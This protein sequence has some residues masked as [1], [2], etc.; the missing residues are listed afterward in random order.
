MSAYIVEDET[1]NKIVRGIEYAMGFHASLDFHLSLDF[2]TKCG[3]VDPQTLGEMLFD[4]NI[5]GVES[6][7]GEGEAGKF[8]P[9]D[10][11][12]QSVPPPTDT[13]FLKSLRCLLYQCSEGD[14]PE[15]PLFKAMKELSHSLALHIV[16]TSACYE[17]ATWG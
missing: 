12:Y 7:Y 17:T 9:L 4:L 10:Y 14:V 3:A 11:K 6:R 5:Q 8:R 2:Y 15:T 1:I 16:S 13:Q